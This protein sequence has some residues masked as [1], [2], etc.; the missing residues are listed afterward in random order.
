[1]QSPD[2]LLRELRHARL[3]RTSGPLP[4]DAVEPYHDRIREAVVARLGTIARKGHHR[5]LAHAL[6]RSGSPDAEALAGH[7]REA[8]DLETAREYAIRAA[9]QAQSALA[10][11]RAARLFRLSLELGPL[12]EAGQ[13]EL[14]HALGEAL[15][16]AGRGAEAAEAYRAAGDGD[17]SLLG[18]HRQRLAAEHLLRSGHIESGALAMS[19]ALRKLGLSVPRR[20]SAALVSLLM[21]RVRIELRDL[22]YDKRS[23][24]DVSAL[25]SAR[26]DGL[27]TA[28]TCLTMFDNVRSAE[29]QSR[30]ILRALEAGSSLQVLRAHTAESI[31]VGTSGAPRAQ[32]LAQ[33]L[34]AA[35]R[36]AT[37]LDDPY[38]WGWVGLSRGA[39]SF[40]LGNWQEGQEQCGLAESIFQTR[41]GAAWELGSAK[42]FGTWSAMMR[43]SFGE[44]SARVPAHVA[45]AESR[46]DLYAATL[47][48]TGFSNAAWLAA[49]DVAQAQHMLSL[50]ERR[51][52][53][54]QF[55][56][57]RYLHMIAGAYIA[58]YERHGSVAYARVLQDW[59]R[60][61]W[62]IAFRAQITRFGMR[63]VRGLSAVAAF[64]ETRDPSLLRDASACAQAIAKEGVTWSQ[65]FAHMIQA[66]V[67]WRRGRASACVQYLASAE[68]KADATGMLLHRA[69][70]R[71]R[72]GEVIGGATGHALVEDGRAFMAREGIVRIDS[73]A[74]LLTPTFPC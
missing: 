72:R 48:M 5:N 39:T 56:V 35:T 34:S 6:M 9:R 24:N 65:C 64:D 2:A 47:H 10:F 30:G 41:A 1:M 26:I 15:V 38:A 19:E 36:L 66:G 33:I 58:L 61:R 49:D 50:A 73:M 12:D 44:V 40:L 46:G 60:L 74:A 68:D 53:G 71:L 8:G 13:R 25:E 32:R 42:A 21:L 62:G 63:T 70:L 11:D 59:R 3:V 69:V 16:S 20:P 7:W 14:Q 27:W 18:L 55:D 45:E 43:G 23:A 54:K 51:W 52:P 22:H 37:E 31:F 4:G 17:D 57:P 28:A 67:A 29:L